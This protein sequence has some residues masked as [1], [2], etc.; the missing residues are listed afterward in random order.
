MADLRLLDSIGKGTELTPEL[1]VKLIEA[2]VK[3]MDIA[4]WWG[5]SKQRVSQ[6]KQLATRGKALTPRE[7]VQEHFPYPG[8]PGRY[9]NSLYK[10][11]RD[12]GEF[13]ATGGEGMTADKLQR[14]RSF[15]LKL[16]ASRTVIVFDPSIPAKKGISTAG[17]WDLVPR[18]PED[19]DSLIRW[20]KHT[21]RTPEGQMIYRFPPELPELLGESDMSGGSDSPTSD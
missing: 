8:L 1:T 5:I 6:L 12:H 10:R 2:G 9:H 16:R 18:T 11:L 17:G 7:Q 13:V 15:Y 4:K 19:K 21:K 14:L 3:Q 20:N